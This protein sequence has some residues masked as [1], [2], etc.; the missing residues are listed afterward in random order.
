MTKMNWLKENW[1]KIGLLIIVILSIGIS[2]YWFSLRPAMIRGGCAV[3]K[4]SGNYTPVAQRT[5]IPGYRLATDDE[6]KA[7]LRTHGL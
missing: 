3:T 6:Y 5:D 4:I 1:F 2:F 7:C